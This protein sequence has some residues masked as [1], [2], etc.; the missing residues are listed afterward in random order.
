[1]GYDIE[2]EQSFEDLYETYRNDVYRVS[3]YYTKDEYISQ[4]I[5]QK[6]FFELY[7]HYDNIDMNK[8]RAY[9]MRATRNTC[10]NWIRDTNREVKQEGFNALP[11]DSLLT[12]SLEDIYIHSECERHEKE[13]FTHIMQSLREENE[14]W[15]DI[16]NLVYCMGKSREEVAE[17]LGMTV[18]VL[19]SK[20]YRAKQWIKR[21][22][23]EEYKKL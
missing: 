5:A 15:Y 1:M 12:R 9:L 7:L 13:F 22:F 20:L 2:K 21:H 18:Q 3:L 17:E 19:Y 4:D 6:V 10:L 14:S 11:D 16:L 8:V 23:E